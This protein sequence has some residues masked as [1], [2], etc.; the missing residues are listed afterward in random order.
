MA[1]SDALLRAL[2]EAA[3]ELGRT[4]ATLEAIRAEF[5][6]LHNF[7][8]EQL[9]VNYRD[10]ADR[11]AKIEENQAERRGRWKTFTAIGAAI[12]GA[13][14]LIGLGIDWLRHVAH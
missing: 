4:T 7:V 5:G 1:D 13:S 2:V 10:L 8:N 3:R 9:A 11:V 14:G 12:A 6:E